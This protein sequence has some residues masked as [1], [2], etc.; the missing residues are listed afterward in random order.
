MDSLTGALALHVA[1]EAPGFAGWARRNTWPGYRDRD[2]VAINAS[3]LGLTALA[4]AAVRREPRL[5]ALWYTGIVAQQLLWNP[6]FHLGATIAY[7]EYSPGLVTA[8]ALFPALW[9]R[10]TR[11]GLAAGHLSRRRV[12]L[13]AAAGGLVHLAAVRKQVYGR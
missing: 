4:G 9:W 1:E 7:R 3:G 13:A 12:A 2:F 6:V 5:F 10:E 8:L 11:R